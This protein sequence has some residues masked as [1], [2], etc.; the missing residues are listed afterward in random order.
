M[1]E[2]R[3]LFYI[4]HGAHGKEDNN[5][6]HQDD[7]L[8][9]I[10]LNLISSANLLDK[11]GSL[12]AKQA[13]INSL[14]QYKVLAILSLEDNLTMSDIRE[15]TFVTKQAVTGLIERMKKNELIETAE[16]QQD[17]R[18]TRIQITSKGKK[19]LQAT[20]PYRVPGNREAFS[21]LN[22]KEIN[23]LAVILEKLVHHLKE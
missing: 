2:L 23:Q 3:L 1:L 16:D 9:D 20:H 14:Q 17:R 12:Y 22:E 6:K 8:I 13:G 10:V 5:L 7:V 4:P 11:K 19:A 18:I 21:V 15:N